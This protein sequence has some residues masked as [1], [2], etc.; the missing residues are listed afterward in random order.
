MKTKSIAHLASGLKAIALLALLTLT[1]TMT[2]AADLYWSGNG[3]T[4]GGGGTW[5]TSSSRWGSTAVG[6]F[7]AWNN[8]NNDL[9]IFAGT[10]G[11][12]TNSLSITNGGVRFDTTAY[13]ITNTT[14]ALLAFGAANNPITFNGNTTAA[15]ITGPVGGTGNVAFS[16]AA[17]NFSG[18]VLTAPGTLTLNGTSSGGWSGTTAINPNMT[19]SLAAANQALKNTTGIFLNGGGITLTSVNGTEGALDR[20]AD[21]ATITVNGGGTI[22]YANSSVANG[23]YAETNGTVTLVSGQLNIVETTSMANGAQSQNNQTL[24][25]AG[26]NRDAGSTNSVITF[27]ANTTGPQAAGN[28]NMIR[29]N[30][31]TTSTAAG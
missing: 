20:V 21:G 13:V 7:S 17:G 19:L 10:A 14:G 6:P 12:V 18:G 27:S 2:H 9:A 23:V 4:L 1:S 26:L 22:S 8:A 31:I 3:S 16:F 24:I 15:T 30:G 11:W 5:D 25:L 29:V 28:R